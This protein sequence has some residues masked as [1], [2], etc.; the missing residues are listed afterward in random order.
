MPVSAFEEAGFKA[1]V[2]D[3]LDEMAA[4][5]R[6]DDIPWVVGYSGGKDSTAVLQL[7][8]TMLRQ[9]DASAR[10][11]PVHV[12]STDTLV[13]NPVVARWVTTSLETM[14]QS[15]RDQSLPVEPHRLTPEV[16]NTFWVNLIGRGYPAPRPKFRWCTER[17]KIKPSNA[18]IRRV[19]RENG[20]DSRARYSQ[21]GIQRTA[22]SDGTAGERARA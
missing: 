1:A 2:K 6:A 11:K 10:H 21:G 12:I 5:Y 7:V 18:F 22:S 13:E 4:L 17:M 8:W 3:L 15:A 19:V 14:E 20:G 9:L 16:S